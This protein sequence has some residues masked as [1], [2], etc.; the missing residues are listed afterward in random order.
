[1]FTISQK[2][3]Q[4]Q[5]IAGDAGVA[6]AFFWRLFAFL[7]ISVAIPNSP[8]IAVSDSLDLFR[9]II[10]FDYIVAALIIIT[11]Y[12]LIGYSLLLLFMFSDIFN[13]LIQAY[14]IINQATDLFAL[15]PFLIYAS[16]KFIAIIIS[17][18]F[19]VIFVVMVMMFGSRYTELKSG[20]IVLNV[21]LAFYAYNVYVQ[22]ISSKA[23]K[24]QFNHNTPIL[25]QL[26]N[27]LNHEA[28]L[29][30]DSEVYDNPLEEVDYTGALSAWSHTPIAEFPERSLLIINES[31]GANTN[32]LVNQSVLKPILDRRSQ[33]INLRYGH[34]K[35]SGLTSTVSAELRELCSLDTKTVNLED[36]TK[37]FESCLPNRLRTAHYETYA[38]HG[39]PARMYYRM[40]WYPRA[41]FEKETF[42]ETKQ[43][44]RKCHSFPGACDLDMESEIIDY[45]SSPGKRFMYWL[46]LN[47]HAFYNLSDLHKDVFECK[48]ASIPEETE[49]CRNLKLQA[50][51]FYGLSELIDNKTMSG[52]KVRV[53]G[54]HMPPITNITERGKYFRENEVGWIEFTIP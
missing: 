28:S 43:W 51:F 38:M 50:Q 14:P 39:A 53:I 9:P 37:G 25:S 34:A 17:V 54:D 36:V 15:T 10:N 24:S 18:I 8:L 30:T 2:T 31:W 23:N 19:V 1:M 27:Y 48:Q 45:F 42:F 33:L 12:R 35:V 3:K 6:S 40:H 22:P 32:P 29:N 5:E 52:V 26:G 41:G 16:W 21:A 13:L 49:T 20:L 44:P 47:T 4:P 11:G 7:I 46:T